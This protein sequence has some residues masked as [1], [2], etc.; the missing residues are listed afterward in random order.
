MEKRKR[1][2]DGGHG[3]GA[4]WPRFG[5]EREQVKVW[6]RGRESKGLGF[7]QGLEQ[8]VTARPNFVLEYWFGARARV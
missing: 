2:Q 3:F 8:E 7:E 5:E 4:R 1:E 6:R